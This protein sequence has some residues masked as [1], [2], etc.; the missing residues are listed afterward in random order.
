MSAFVALVVLVLVAVSSFIVS[1]SSSASAA[2]SD[3]R[4]VSLGDWGAVNAD[5]AAVARQIGIHAESFN[6][7]FLLAVGDNFYDVT[8]THAH[9]HTRTH[10]H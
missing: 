8:R 5:Q 2:V 3:L 10:R 9:T 4:F 1:A 6:A 7:S